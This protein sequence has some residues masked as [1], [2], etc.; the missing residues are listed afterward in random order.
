MLV[1]SSP[2]FNPKRDG[3]GYE[4]YSRDAIC[5]ECGSVIGSQ[6]CYEHK[7]M[8]EKF[9]FENR[10]KNYYEFCPYCGKKLKKI[11]LKKDDCYEL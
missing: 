5:G 11:I 4:Y 6:S 10:D 8:E 2:R 9:Y 7:P 1:F 3:H